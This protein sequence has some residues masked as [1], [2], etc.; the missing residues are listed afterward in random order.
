MTT[1]HSL[2]VGTSSDLAAGDVFGGYRIDRFLG[3]GGMGTVYAAEQI[4]DGR[5]VAVKMLSTG[6]SSDEDR[7]R[8]LREG[9]T[10]A[11][12]NHP[13]TVYVYRTE[14]IEGVPTIVMELVE[15][16]TL[17]EKVERQGPLPIVE[18]INDILQIVDGLDAA[19]REGILH[20]DIK[21]A[22]CFV[23]PTGEVKVGDFGLS[24]PV[25]QVDQL[26]LTQ[27][28]MF[29]GTPVF[30]SPEQLLGESLDLR[31]DIYAVGATLYFLLTGKFPYSAVNSAQLL[32][33]VIQG[34]PTPLAQYRADVPEALSTVVTTCLSR[35]REKR[36]ADYASLRAAL[37]ACLP[38]EVVPAP[39]V[40]RLAAGIIDSYAIGIAATPAFLFVAKSIG[41]SMATVSTDVRAQQLS[42]L[43]GVPLQLVWYMLLEGRLGWS[44][45][46]LALGLR[47]VQTGG[48]PPGIAKGFLRALAIMS[49]GFVGLCGALLFEG[50]NARGIASFVGY[51]VMLAALFARAR[52][53]NG[54]LAEHDR[55]TNTRVI[56]AKFAA[57]PARHT[58]AATPVARAN[59][60][61][62]G[63]RGPFE[64]VE[65]IAST[66]T[67]YAGHD[68]ALRRDVWIV[69][70]NAGA[71]AR[72]LGERQAV[73][74]GCLRWI[75]GR[76]TD[77]EAWDA[78]AAV[79]GATLRQ[80]L[81]EGVEWSEVHGWLSDLVEE[82]TARDDAAAHAAQLTAEHVWITNDGHAL[83][84]PFAMT[85]AVRP[86]SAHVLRDVA[87]VLAATDE[88][89]TQRN[90]WPLRARRVEALI[91]ADPIDWTALRR[92]LTDA[93]EQTA[94]MSRRTRLKLWGTMTAP[95]AIMVVFSLFLAGFIM[96]KDTEQERMEPLLGYLA[97]KRNRGTAEAG[98]RES[99][100]VY[101]A[102]HFRAKIAAPRPK[103]EVVGSLI[104]S[105]KEW[106]RADSIVAAHPTVSAGVLQKVDQLVDST[107]KG[108][109]PGEVTRSQMFRVIGFMM[110]VWMLAFF[111]VGATLI[112]RRGFPM[113]V[114]AL[115]LVNRRSEPA[116]RLL[117]IWRQ[118]LVWAPWILL[119]LIPITLLELRPRAPVAFGLTSVA[120]L[121]VLASVISAWRTPSRGLTERLSGTRMVRE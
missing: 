40:R 80:R 37:Q 6:L 100:A 16:G 82:L 114:L 71:A 78:Y 98:N 35:Q 90:S 88:R 63:I 113:R 95:A 111:S 26:R 22:N 4:D 34:T 39:F 32:A 55:F 27:T 45:G 23:G 7:R 24:R 121:V 47:V 116:G 10:A 18:A 42:A 104:L 31:A 8:F 93:G 79:P 65:R 56:R 83:L 119:S 20:R 66:E 19:Q 92:A 11:S 115:D 110:V 12:I 48:G 61:G 118:C 81:S 76:R 67:A 15:G 70:Q 64:L 2:R 109:P 75:A 106:A 87:A 52:R 30:S 13:N 46:K 102:G 17:E 3:R 59:T 9:H 21:P 1:S 29:L 120:I 54:W 74:R 94:V 97:N 33:Q 96:P 89:L 60:S 103:P 51:S 68:A 69:E 101:I 72:P 58:R 53:A 107:W 38:A 117:L 14:E 28:G 108:V 84:L 112:A 5:I 91:T 36:Y 57:A 41:V 77:A 50:V 62:L 86:A 44:P 73:R 105:T 85:A 25:D 99:V 43:F 49:P